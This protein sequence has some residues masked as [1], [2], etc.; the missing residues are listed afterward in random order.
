[1]ALQDVVDAISRWGRQHLSAPD[2]EKP[3][4][5]PRLTA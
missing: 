2:R 5:G 1:V 4:R 3:R